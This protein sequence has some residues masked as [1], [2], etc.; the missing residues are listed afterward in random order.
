MSTKITTLSELLIAKTALVGTNTSMLS[1]VI[2]KVARLVEL[3]FASRIITFEHQLVSI[4]TWVTNFNNFEPIFWCIFES[5]PFTLIRLNYFT[6]NLFYSM[7]RM[8][9]FISFTFSL[10]S[11]SSWH[12][13][14]GWDIFRYLLL[15]SFIIWFLIRNFLRLFYNI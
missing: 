14:G 2:S 11:W 6:F 9:A 3:S 5:L 4:G 12:K 15:N 1:E 8:I 7:F 13:S 10:C